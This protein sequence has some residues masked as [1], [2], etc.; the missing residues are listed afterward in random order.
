MVNP[1]MGRI[2]PDMS[3]ANTL[4]ANSIGDALFG[5]TRQAVLKLFF[6][7][8]DQRFYQKQIV[9]TLSFGSGSVQRELERLT[10][11]GILTRVVE[12]RQTYFQ[13]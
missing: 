4:P 8:S 10:R 12:G 13:P 1:T 7:H 11:A 2:A 3:S 6:G 9:R 5:A